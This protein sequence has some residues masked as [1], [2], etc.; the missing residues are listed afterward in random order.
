MCSV[1][2]TKGGTTVCK[3]EVRLRGREGR[4]SNSSEAKLTKNDVVVVPIALLVG[5]SGANRR[6]PCR[7]VSGQAHYFS[8]PL[9]LQSIV[10]KAPNP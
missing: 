2:K 6:A 9:M 7:C 3:L 8:A 5:S 1:K 4:T 10:G